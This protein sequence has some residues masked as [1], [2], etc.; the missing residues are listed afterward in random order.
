MEGR[1]FSKDYYYIKKDDMVI[2][3]GFA[4][5]TVAENNREE[6]FIISSSGEVLHYDEID[7]IKKP[8]PETGEYRTVYFA[9]GAI[10]RKKQ[11]LEMQKEGLL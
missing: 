8:N 7:E 1:S 10:K 4:C 2:M 5:F 3:Y 11:I 9:P 6:K